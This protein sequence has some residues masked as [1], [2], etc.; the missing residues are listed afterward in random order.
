MYKLAG[1]S[2]FFLAL[3]L[4]ISLG[5]FSRGAMGGLSF[6]ET[7][8]FALIVVVSFVGP[9]LVAFKSI[10]GGGSDEN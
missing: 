4:F 7:F 1:L 5:W 9:L 6:I 8:L 2:S 10:L 3:A